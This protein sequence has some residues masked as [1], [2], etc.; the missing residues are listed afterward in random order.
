M[1]KS[2]RSFNFTGVSHCLSQVKSFIEKLNPQ[3]V[4][5]KFKESLS[6]PKNDQ[7]EEEQESLF[8]L[9]NN[10]PGIKNRILLIFGH[11]FPSVAYLKYRYKIKTTI[12]AVLYYPVRWVKQAG[13]LL[14]VKT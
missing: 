13:K 5:V 11:I 9:L 4:S 6:C 1:L 3:P 2:L 7:Q 12:G 14:G 8:K 10:V